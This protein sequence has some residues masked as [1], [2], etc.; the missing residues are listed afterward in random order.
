M[1]KG[2]SKVSIGGIIINYKLI[3]QDREIL[4][5]NQEEF[6]KLVNSGVIGWH[7][8]LYDTVYDIH[9]K[10]SEIEELAKI[11]PPEKIPNTNSMDPVSQAHLES[12]NPSVEKRQ[13]P[14]VRYGLPG[15][16]VT[17]GII[18]IL[19]KS[20]I[21][22]SFN[23]GSMDK[24]YLVGN[25]TGSV[26]FSAIFVIIVWAIIWS[27]TRKRNKSISLLIFSLIYIV[28]SFTSLTGELSKIAKEKEEL[29]LS[30]QKT[31]S[32]MKEFIS[33]GEVK[34]EAISK[35]KY[36]K[37]SSA[38]EF[39]QDFL[40]DFSDRVKSVNAKVEEIDFENIMSPTALKDPKGIANSKQVVNNLMN[41]FSALENDLKKIVDDYN[42]R[43]EKLDLPRGYKEGFVKGFGSSR[44]IIMS[45]I[46]EYYG[47]E[48][49]IFNKVL[50]ILD[51]METRRG[52]Y[53]VVNG[54]LQF[55]SV[56]DVN[57]YN[58]LIDELQKLADEETQ[59]QEK[60]TER[61]KKNMQDYEEK[62][63]QLLK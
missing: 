28:Y 6:I 14:F 18:F 55:T 54:V 9:M 2:H 19:I 50:E 32:M 10:V 17:A 36:G 34:K 13:H 42:K 7:T 44:D 35:E 12:V 62:V 46:T 45:Q 25:I 51:F 41:D 21:R 27:A 58:K 61:S 24:A 16:F 49:D 48:R 26:T 40:T 57:A 31:F 22:A 39:M 38:I 63:Q 52:K 5:S 59:W 20:F 56:D 3:G 11:F 1:C 30:S 8:V 53:S 23:A 15:L 37:T 47:I 60:A 29:K 33:K 43:A 4:I